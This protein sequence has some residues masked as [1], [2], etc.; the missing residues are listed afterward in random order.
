MLYPDAWDLLRENGNPLVND[1][2][3]PITPEAYSGWNGVYTETIVSKLSVR[4]VRALVAGLRGLTDE[5]SD[6]PGGAMPE[7][8]ILARLKRAWANATEDER[9][10]FIEWTG[11]VDAAAKAGFAQGY[12]QGHADADLRSRYS[13]ER[14]ELGEELAAEVNGEARS[15]AADDPIELGR[16]VR[17]ARKARGWSQGALADAAGTHPPI[18]SQIERGVVGKVG[19]ATLQ[20]VVETVLL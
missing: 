11:A 5:E 1:A 17:A 2:G 7:A 9:R 18:I 12:R 6:Q 16:R 10:E 20:R 19:K 4:D 14:E 13:P 15:Y 3:Q 8:R